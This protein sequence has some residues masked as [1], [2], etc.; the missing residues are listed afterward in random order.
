M[1]NKGVK[2]MVVPPLRFAEFRDTEGWEE[3]IIGNVSKYENGKAHEQDIAEKGK[4]I[5]VNSKFIST[6][7]E[8]KK[9]I[10]TPFCIAKKGD[11]LMVLSDVPNGRAIAKCFIVDADNLYT[12]NQRICKITPTKANGLF[13]YN[14]L[15]RNPYFL[16]FDDGVKQTNLKNDDVLSCP[17][18]LP[19]DL[20]EQQKIADCLSS[21]DDLITAES[22]K[23]DA[24]KG[25]KKGLMQQLFPADGETVPQLRFAEWR[26]SEGWEEVK[27]GEYTSKI[28]SG[29]TPNGGDKN[30][31]KT[32]RPFVRS[33]NIG[34]GQLILENVAFIDEA[35]HSTFISTEIELDDVLLNITGAS[36]GR[37]AVADKR[38]AGGNVN[39]HVCIIRADKKLNSYFLN[40][41]LLSERGQKQIDNFQTGGNRQGLNFQQIRSMCISIPPS[42]KEQQKIADCLSS[43]DALINAESEKLEALK[44]HK[45]G[46]MQ[47]LF[48]SV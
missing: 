26:D 40:Q 14:I 25:H 30:Y 10:N 46:L 6:D 12:V 17:I 19:K 11:I 3:N 48:P 23:L 43:L 29:I 4:F 1:K 44:G 22:Q 42:V 24:L 8:V 34:W 38:I 18:V 5:V 39:Q 32:G 9:F 31:K 45:K 13:L 15:N 35:T 7:S 41:Y 33:Q 37:S 27:I 21:L 16:A 28:G 47:Q 20:K 36:I 2:N